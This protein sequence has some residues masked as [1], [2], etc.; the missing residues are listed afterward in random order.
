MPPEL[1]AAVDAGNADEVKKL[2]ATVPN[3]SKAQQKKLIKQ[4]DITAKK[5]AKGGSAAASAKP[6][7]AKPAA[8]AA[9]P[10][11]AKPAA[12]AA[13]AAPPPLPTGGG[14]ASAS[15]RALVSDMLAAIAALE[16]PADAM[17]TLRSHEAELAA[18]IAPRL[19]ALQNANY[20]SGFAARE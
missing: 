3:L 12:A 18:A 7:A 10:A 17:A 1:Q 16:L 5:L 19:N 14:V 8:A 11:A 2:A 20:A 9:K 4:A 13:A 15:E 6:A